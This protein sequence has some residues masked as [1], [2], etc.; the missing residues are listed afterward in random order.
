MEDLG[1]MPTAMADRGWMSSPASGLGL[2]DPGVQSFARGK[3]LGA[4]AVSHPPSALP[5]VQQPFFPP[6]KGFS[7][8]C[9]QIAL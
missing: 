1:A 6:C 9:E 7:A 4:G 3:S 8:S 5:R 2:G